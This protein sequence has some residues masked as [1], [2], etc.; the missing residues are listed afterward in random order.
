MIKRLWHFLF[1]HDW[2]WKSASFC[3]GNGV[4]LSGGAE[5]YY[6]KCWGF[7]AILM[8]CDCGK[9]LSWRT[10]GAHQ[11]TFNGIDRETD[12]LRKMAGL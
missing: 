2:K 10:T 7:T 1:G 6:E 11:E 12:E 5:E 8:V 9:H 3:Q 4:V